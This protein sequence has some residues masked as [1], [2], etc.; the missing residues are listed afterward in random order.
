MEYMKRGAKPLRLPSIRF[1]FR[2]GT[3][4]F[5]AGKFENKAG[6]TQWLK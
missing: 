1:C 2:A 4:C 5:G 3:G 6:V